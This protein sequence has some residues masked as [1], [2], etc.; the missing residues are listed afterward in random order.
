MQAS[1]SRLHGMNHSGHQLS[2]MDK[3]MLC[4]NNKLSVEP[5]L[6]LVVVWNSGLCFFLYVCL[7][8]KTSEKQ[9]P[10]DLDKGSEGIFLNS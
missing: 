3:Y 1:W 2:Y 10:I 9:I 4:Q 6:V 8:F 5:I 7:Y